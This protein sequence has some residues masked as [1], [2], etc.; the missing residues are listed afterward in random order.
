MFYEVGLAQNVVL[1]DCVLVGEGG[2]EMRDPLYIPASL[3][4][5]LS[6]LFLYKT[7]ERSPHYLKAKQH[8]HLTVIRYF[9]HFVHLFNN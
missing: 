2:Y 7:T 4:I 9:H 5:N 3:K 6:G 1:Q 8:L